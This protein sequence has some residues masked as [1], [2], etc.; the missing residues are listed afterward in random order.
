VIVH[1]GG[2]GTTFGALAHGVPQVIVPQGADN[3]DNAAM[4]ERAGMAVVLRPDEFSDI[5]TLRALFGG[6]PGVL[7]LRTTRPHDQ[8]GFGDFRPHG[9]RREDARAESVVSPISH[10][11]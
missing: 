6:L 7:N 3:Y 11:Q 8:A 10:G 1:H 9:R 4:C 5:R 2:T